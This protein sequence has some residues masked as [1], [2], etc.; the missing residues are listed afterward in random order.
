MHAETD[1][2]S[3]VAHARPRQL[4]V[5]VVAAILEERAA[6]HAPRQR[7]CALVVGRER[8]RRETVGRVIHQLHGII[9]A[10]D[11]HHAQ[12]WPERLLHHNVH[13][14]V[15]VCE[16]RR[17][18]EASLARRVGDGLAAAQQRRA[19]R[20]RVLHL[21]VEERRSVRLRQRPHRRARVHG[22]A[23]LIRVDR[24]QRALHEVVVQR[25]RDVHAL[26]AAARLPGVE[27]CAIHKRGDGSIEV[28]VH[29]DVGGVLTAKLERR[30]DEPRPSHR[31]VDRV[32]ATHRTRERHEADFRVRDDVFH[33]SVTAVQ[34]RDEVSRDAGRREGARKGLGA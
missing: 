8:H 24:G 19:A 12:D 2:L 16:Q 11:G 4:G 31:L 22:V 10:I 6:R 33:H 15:A 32:A 17:R 27:E 7:L 13:L 20:H 18:E 9:V 28:G 23:Q 1:A 34:G 21:R 25:P 3:R 14:V 26:D 5:Q 29:S 30:V